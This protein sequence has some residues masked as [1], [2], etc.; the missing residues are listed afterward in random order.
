MA[1]VLL[2][3][4]FALLWLQVW[5][6]RTWFG[7]AALSR[8]G[9]FLLAYLLFEAL[10]LTTTERGVCYGLC[11]QHAIEQDRPARVPSGPVQAA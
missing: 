11:D 10:P 6:R 9:A 4:V 8:R 2:P 3:L 5:S 1:I 7:S